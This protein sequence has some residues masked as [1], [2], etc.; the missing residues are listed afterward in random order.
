MSLKDL[1]EASW[2][3]KVVLV[4]WIV[5]GVFV[6]FLLGRID[7]IIHNDLYGFGLQFSFVWADP[8]WAVL[9][10]IYVCVAVPSV[11]SAVALGLDF[12][13]KIHG[14]KRASGGA[15]KP[16]G[17]KVQSLKSNHMLISCP[18]CRRT[19]GKPLVMLDFNNGKAKLVS[20]CPYCN[21]RLGDERKKDI[22]VGFLGP[23][24]RVKT[25]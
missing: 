16:A 7:Y 5:S 17:G 24:E 6:L 15:G 8:Y 25:E 11:L 4:L 19:F 1:L 23:D 20:V 9:R 18:S 14:V 21:S 2:F 3:T 13:G 12:K 22:E 10:L